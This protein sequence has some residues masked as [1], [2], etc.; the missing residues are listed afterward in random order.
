MKIGSEHTHKHD[1]LYERLD[2]LFT[3]AQAS[4]GFLPT[5]IK[6][7]ALVFFISVRHAYY[8]SISFACS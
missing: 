8:R 5:Q 4:L 6:T 2:L 7:E 1:A 3:A